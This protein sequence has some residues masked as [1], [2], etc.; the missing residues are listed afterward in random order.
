MGHPLRPEYLEGEE[1][2][3]H[4]VHTVYLLSIRPSLGRHIYY[5]FDA[6]LRGPYSTELATD[7]Y[8][9]ASH[10]LSPTYVAGVEVDRRDR[11]YGDRVFNTPPDL[12]GVLGTIYELARI[13]ATLDREVL[14]EVWGAM[15]PRQSGELG[16][17][18]ETI[19][20]WIEAGYIP[21]PT[22][23]DETHL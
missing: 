6:Y 19:R 23:L 1:D 10:E 7:L 15:E 8:S 22:G 16:W 14:T 20:G 3:I 21:S 4:T 18:V 2:V 5:V 9:Y 12:R 11:E 17:A 13:H